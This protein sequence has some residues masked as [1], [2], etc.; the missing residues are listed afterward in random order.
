MEPS[1]TS[2]IAVETGGRR[3][4]WSLAQRLL[5]GGRVRPRGRPAHPAGGDGPAGRPQG[6]PGPAGHSIARPL[7][8]RHPARH[9]PGLP[10]SG[11][12]RRA[13]AGRPDPGR[14]RAGSPAPSRP[15]ATHAVAV[16]IAFTIIT[17][18]AHHP[19]RA[20]AQGAGAALS[21]SGER[22]GGGAA[23]GVRLGHGPAHRRSSTAP[24]TAC[25]GCCTSS[26]PAS[27]SGCTRR[28]RSGCWWS[29]ARKAGSLGKE[30]A[31]LLEGVFEFSEKTAQE[32]MTPRTQMVALE[33]DLPVEE[34]AD[35]VAQARRSRYPVYGES[36]DDIVGRGARQGHPHRAS[37]SSRR[38]T[39]GMH[40]A[41]AAL[42]ARHPRGRGRAGRHEAAQ[43]PPRAW[44]STSTAAPRAWSRWR[45]CSR[46][47]WATSST[48]T[49]G[50][51]VPSP[52][53]RARRAR[54]GL[55][56]SDFNAEHD[57][58]ARRHRL[59]HH[60]RLPLRPAG[61][62]AQG[63]ATGSPAGKDVFEI[64]EMDGP[65]GEDASGF[66]S[67]G[68]AALPPARA[69]RPKLPS[70]VADAAPDAVTPRLHD[71]PIAPDP[72]R[73]PG[74]HR[75][76]GPCPAAAAAAAADVLE[77]A[78]YQELLPPTFEYEEVFLRAGGPEV[79]E[80]LIR[81][82][83]RDG[84]ILALRYDFTASLARVAATTFRT[85]A[86]CRSGSA[87]AARCSARSPIAAAGPG[88]RC[89]PAPSCWGRAIS[90][91][92]SRSSG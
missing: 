30:D 65:P 2:R 66:W 64:V 85:A 83:D 49:T 36:L 70:A 88:R 14:L 57:A 60:R 3:C 92:T 89:R 72:S 47:S 59:H 24:P 21:G 7:H 39:V 75:R 32:V 29:R 77:R 42:R 62:A 25:S 1:E 12:D 18:A 46:R 43:G 73:R 87:T 16:A 61:P 35:V 11:L 63:R 71:P 81:F 8:L 28:K 27:T 41:P 80:R 26:R 56:I 44:C 19:G 34:A 53:R 48:S 76:R 17:V 69:R 58:A 84:R 91:P 13:G 68:G 79:A 40:H 10:R 33:R 55:T 74:S 82:T 54:R 45:T 78:G 31:R 86:R 5:R 90:P 38:A 23:D 22:L 50:S 4:C 6:R 51:T 67:G 52:P 20:G 15:I 37:A 9:H